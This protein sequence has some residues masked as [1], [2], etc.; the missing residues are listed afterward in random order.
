MFP[1]L[2]FDFGRVAD[3]IKLVDLMIVP[4]RHHGASYEMRRAEIAAHRIQGDLHWWETL[5]TKASDCKAKNGGAC[6][7]RLLFYVGSWHSRRLDSTSLR[8]STPVAHGNNHTT[9]KRYAIR[10]RCHIAGICLATGHAS[11]SPLCANAIASSKFCVL[12]LPYLTSRER[13]RKP[14]KDNSETFFPFNFSLSNSLQFDLPFAPRSATSMCFALQMRPPSRSQCGC[15]G[16]FR[17]RSS[18]MNG[19]RSTASGPRSSVCTANAGTSISW[20]NSS[21]Q[22]TH[23]SSTGWE[24]DPFAQSAPDETPM[25]ML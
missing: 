2:A 20:T 14:K 23:R 5:R 18:R 17:R 7:K 19:V 8:V 9:D 22:D 13:S 16:R 24:R 25:S 3:E 10:L 12:G 15:A 11:G 21:R 6:A 1:Q 4:Q